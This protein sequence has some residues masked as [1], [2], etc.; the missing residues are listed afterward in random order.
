MVLKLST[1]GWV[2]HDL[3]YYVSL[4]IRHKR[5]TLKPMPHRSDKSP[6]CNKFRHSVNYKENNPLKP[7]Y[8]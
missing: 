6:N 7:Q 8:S 1:N 2:T 4:I 5:P 3:F